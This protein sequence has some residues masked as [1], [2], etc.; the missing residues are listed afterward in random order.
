ML[1]HRVHP[2]KPFAGLVFVLGVLG[3]LLLAMSPSTARAI[4][5]PPGGALTGQR[6]RVIVSTDIGGSDHDDSQ[7]MVHLLLYSDIFDIEGLISSPPGAGRDDDIHEVIDQYEADYSKLITHSSSYPSVSYLRSIT[8]QGA[9]NGSAPGQGKDTDGSNW[10]IAR[11]QASDS[12]PLYVLVWGSLTDVAQAVY[13]APSIKSKI[14]VLCTSG[15]TGFNHNG[16]PASWDYLYNNHPDLWLINTESSFRGMY[17]DSWNTTEWGNGKFIDVHVEGHG[18]LGAYFASLN[19]FVKMGDTPLVLY[20]MRGNP[21]SPTTDHWG[22]RFQST[23]HGPNYWTDITDPAWASGGYNG[24]KTVSQYHDNFMADFAVRF[25]WAKTGSSTPPPPPPPPPPTGGLISNVTTSTGTNATVDTLAVGKDVY[26]DRDYTF[27]GVPAAFVGHEY[28]LTANNDKSVTSPN[29]LTFTLDEAATVYVA[30][31]ERW[32]GNLPT[33][34]SSWSQEAQ[35]LT[36]TDAVDRV[37]YSKAFPA[38]QVV[39][40]GNSQSPDSSNYSV[41][42]VPAQGGGEVALQEDFNGAGSPS[43]A[44]FTTSGFGSWTVASNAT[45]GSDALRATGVTSGSANTRALTLVSGVGD[46]FTASTKFV[47]NQAS[48]QPGGTSGNLNSGLLLGTTGSTSESPGILTSVMFQGW[49][50]NNAGQMQIIGLGT[51]GSGGNQTVASGQFNGT[52]APLQVGVVYTL[53]AVVTPNGSGGANVQFTVAQAG[54]PSTTIN[55]QITD[56][57]VLGDYFGVRHRTALWNTSPT[58]DISF[59][60]YTIIK[61]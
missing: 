52:I 2:Q 19:E 47:I 30:Y 57:S 29:Y 13:D 18:A 37:L 27:T 46:S 54:G 49:G 55:G 6:Y 33:W 26:I 31:D 34:L 16:D 21:D 50:G 60:D 32:V 10:I 24:A 44:G 4:N 23:S 12:R 40:G 25:D 11:A 5:D 8:K 48:A 3:A 35:I 14:R 22:G 58:H 56:A 45:L 9:I 51:N 36:T 59:D 1:K 7:S 53:T 43:G 39:L 20:L 15:G 41:I 28:I 61:P 38:G 17:I 42:A